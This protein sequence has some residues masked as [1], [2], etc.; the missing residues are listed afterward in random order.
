MALFRSSCLSIVALAKLGFFARLRTK[1]YP[2][3]C[4]TPAH[5]ELVEGLV[6]FFIALKT[7]LFFKVLNF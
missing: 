4:P 5:P 3:L 2:K 6:N 1:G 7:V